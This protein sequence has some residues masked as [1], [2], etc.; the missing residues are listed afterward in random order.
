[1]TDQNPDELGDFDRSDHHKHMDY[2]QAVITRL[3][4]NSFLLKGWALT[5]S[6][7]LLGFAITQNHAGLALAAIVPV[8]AFWLLDTYYL[9]QER[10]FRNMYDD[11]ATKRLRDFKID[12]K[13]YAEAQPWSIGF[14]VSLRIFYLAIITLTLVVATIL[15]VAAAT[16]AQHNQPE[17]HGNQNTSD[18][19]SSSSSAVQ[20][21]Q[22]SSPTT[23]T[24]VTPRPH[25]SAQRSVEPATTPQPTIQGTPTSTQR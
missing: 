21:S 1:M 23:P 6:S 13:L 14:S 7:A 16:S 11:V 9:R 24:A 15:A 25:E 5:L 19:Q 22:P 18:E 12:P 8:I 2:V 4:N 10:A 20:S 17:P 3:A